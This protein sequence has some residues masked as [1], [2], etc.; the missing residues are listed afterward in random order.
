MTQ[1][2]VLPL[3]PSHVGLAHNLITVGNKGGIDRIAITDPKETLPTSDRLPQGAESLGAMVANSPS[4]N[5]WL[6]VVDDSPNPHLVTLSAHKSL[7][8]VEFTDLRNCLRVVSIGQTF[9]DLGQPVNHR[10]VGHSHDP[11]NAAKSQT[12]DIHSQT[13]AFGPI[14][15]STRAIVINKLAT[16]VYT[17]MILLAST[18]AILANVMMTAFRTLHRDSSL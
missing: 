17:D 10:G 6:K 4:Q 16:A 1:T 7:Q 5:P 18:M 8:L 2:S 3:H 9:T 14:A 13:Q 15:V 12:V 11:F